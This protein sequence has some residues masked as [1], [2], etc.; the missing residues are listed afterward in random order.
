M[1]HAITHILA[2]AAAALATAP[3]PAQTMLDK[4]IQ[5][6]AKPKSSSTIPAA[7]Q[8]TVSPISPDQGVAIDRL[9]AAPL[10]DPQVAAA[11]SEAAP[12]I[13]KMLATGSCARTSAAWHTLNRDRLTPQTYEP[14]D[15]DSAALAD[16]RYHD[17]AM[18]LDVLR[19]ANWSKPAANAI[20]F[21]AFYVAADSGEAKS[22]EFELQ[23]QDGRWLVRTVGFAL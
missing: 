20:F 9:L 5:K 11:R 13:R 1:R 21:K 6:V 3:A 12:L 18:C 10:A 17:K 7:P 2:A 8:G 23:K 14:W 4:L 15:R 22:Q 19:L 16:L